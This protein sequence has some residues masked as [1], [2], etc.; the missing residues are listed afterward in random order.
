MLE[1]AHSLI[2]FLGGPREV[3][4]LLGRH[5]SRI[6]RWTYPEERGGT[7]GLIP[8]KEQVKLLAVSEEHALGLE[9]GDFFT[10]ARLRTLLDEAKKLEAAE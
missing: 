3:A 4:G 10:S 1:P 7:G 5:I 8:S 9:P 6:Y 2:E